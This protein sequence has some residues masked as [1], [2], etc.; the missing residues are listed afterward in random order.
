MNTESLR[1]WIGR[2][3]VLEDEIAA[4]P[5]R[6]LSATLECEAPPVAAGSI[7]PPLWHWLYF[8][9]PC[10]ASEVDADGHPRRGGFLPPVALPRRMW[11]GGR[12]EWACDN[13][14]KMGETARRISRIKSISEKQ[15]R[16][17]PLVFVTVLHEVHNQAGLCV[18]EE[19]DIVYKGAPQPGDPDPAPATVPP[20]AW[21]RELVPDEV[22]LFRYSALTFN[23]HRIHYDRPYATSVEAYPGLVV[24]GPLIATLLLDALH[25]QTP[26]ARVRI[27]EFKAVRPS[28]DSRPLV[29]NGTP[30]GDGNTVKLW[31]SDIDGSVAMR[32]E[33]RLQ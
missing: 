1:E 5:G 29:L 10:P 28:F 9:R 12:L 22:L 11:A 32:A 13:P 30:E 31:A 3:Q 33:V 27:F 23:G 21:R 24:H 8:L 26:E 17:G 20:G 16:S 18:S 4:A 2:E 25:R 19:Q 15:G 14:L 6:A 7:V